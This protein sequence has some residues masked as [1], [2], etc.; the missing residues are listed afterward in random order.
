M[1]DGASVSVRDLSYAYPDSEATVLED[2]AVEVAS[3]D[4]HAVMGAN[5]AGKT[6]LLKL[7]AGLREPDGGRVAFSDPDAVVGFAPADPQAGFFAPTVAAEVAF[8]PRNRGLDVD[9]RVEDALAA[10]DAADLRDRSPHS[11]SGGEQRRVSVASVLAG[12]PAVL[13][14][15]EPTSG[16]HS[17]GERAL[18]TLLS[19]LE[20]TVLF[21]THA[22][23]FVYEYADAVTVLDGGRV[24]ETGPPRDVLADPEHLA[25]VGIRPPGVVEWAARHSLPEPP[26]SITEAARGVSDR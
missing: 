26:A 12:D 19:S 23:D 2:V 3:G 6:T 9:A 17:H 15:D 8:F 20:R 10:M 14:L 5:G 16:L 25:D 4:A 24:V 18:G 11:L 1:T 22:S 13:A 7:V 21:S